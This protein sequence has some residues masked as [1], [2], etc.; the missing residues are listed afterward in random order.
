MH[1]LYYTCM[2]QIALNFW[3]SFLLNLFIPYSYNEY[4][5]DLLLLKKYS[6]DVKILH[7]L[8]SEDVVFLG[9]GTQKFQEDWANMNSYDF[10]K[11]C[12]TRGK[13]KSW[14]QVLK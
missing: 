10:T 12:N 11:I 2:Q 7:N 13:E 14:S 3:I 8:F 4:Q 5:S 1:I 6:V 9:D